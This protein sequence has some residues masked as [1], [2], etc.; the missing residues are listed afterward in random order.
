MRQVSLPNRN[1]LL[2]ANENIRFECSQLYNFIIK[3]NDQIH[4][5]DDAILPVDWPVL[6]VFVLG[7]DCGAFLAKSNRHK[8]GS[9]HDVASRVLRVSS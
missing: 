8:S 7:W 3:P 9:V 4:L 2:I 5:R 1:I 6:P